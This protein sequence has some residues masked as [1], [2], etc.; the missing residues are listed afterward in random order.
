MKLKVKSVHFDADQ[1]LLSF[2]Q[3]KVDKLEHFYENIMTGEVSLR[4]E[5][6]SDD[7]NKYVQIRLNVPGNDLVA[8]EQ[9]K[10]F[11]EATDLAV[12]ALRKQILKHKE[13]VR[14]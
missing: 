13:K 12:E 1:K 10:T 2:I 4:V 6:S 7:E 11:E 5:N 3:E 9:C 14:S 8:K